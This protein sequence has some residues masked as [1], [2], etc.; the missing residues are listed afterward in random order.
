MVKKTTEAVVPAGRDWRYRGWEIAVGA[1]DRR[2]AEALVTEPQT[3]PSVACARFQPLN[4]L[5]RWRVRQAL[6]GNYAPPDLSGW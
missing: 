3:L 6:L 5:G 4:R 2:D 1:R